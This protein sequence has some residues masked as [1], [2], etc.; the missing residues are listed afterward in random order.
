MCPTIDYNEI[1]MCGSIFFGHFGSTLVKR[2]PVTLMA[3]IRLL[4]R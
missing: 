3:M 2:R 4:Y 1:I